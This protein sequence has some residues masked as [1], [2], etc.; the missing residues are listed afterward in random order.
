MATVTMTEKHKIIL[1]A[2]YHR[3]YGVSPLVARGSVESHAKKH[4]LRGAEYGEA[5]E[6]ADSDKVGGAEENKERQ[7]RQ[8]VQ[9]R[10]SRQGLSSAG[11]LERGRAP[12]R[13]LRAGLRLNS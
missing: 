7:R 4:D 1:G 2:F 3:R 12:V 5:L 13:H 10:R 8:R 6:S 9:A 11:P